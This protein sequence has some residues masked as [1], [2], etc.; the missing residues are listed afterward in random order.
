M[1]LGS[2]TLVLSKLVGL[3]GNVVALESSKLVYLI[4]KHGVDNLGINYPNLKYL[5]DN[6]HI[7][8]YNYKD[9][10]SKLKPGTFDVIYFDPMFSKPI[11]KSKPISPLRSLACTDCLDIETVETAKKGC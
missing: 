2:D 5:K 4:V 8:N 10:L 3:N 9:F 6:I 1:G 7:K 11:Q